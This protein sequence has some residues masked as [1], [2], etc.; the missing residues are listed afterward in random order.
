MQLEEHVAAKPYRA[1][2]A[3]CL[4]DA[5]TQALRLKKWK[6]DLAEAK[7]ERLI[8]MDKRRETMRRLND[9]ICYLRHR[10]H[11]AQVEREWLMHDSEELR[12]FAGILGHSAEHYRQHFL[13][14]ERAGVVVRKSNAN[15]DMG[16]REYSRSVA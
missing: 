9:R 15:G 16:T 12:L 2:A 13:R 7:R 6:R 14:L 3:A 10:V 8:N 5:I 4:T 11:D 1:C